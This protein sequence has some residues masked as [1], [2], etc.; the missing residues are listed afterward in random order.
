M[1]G[2]ALPDRN[3]HDRIVQSIVEKE[4]LMNKTEFISLVAEKTG[5]TKTDAT[6][7]VDAVLSALR[8][9]MVAG[10]DV[11]FIG[12]GTFGVKDV[13]EREARNPQTGE[14]IRIAAHRSPF[15]KAGKALKDAVK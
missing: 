14:T 11:T 10:E 6:K 5:S 13:A 1:T 8:D 12:F 9:S 3:T 15:F 7:A 2:K 4:K